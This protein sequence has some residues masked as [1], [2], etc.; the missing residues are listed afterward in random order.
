[1][2]TPPPAAKETTVVI[3]LDFWH[4]AKFSQIIKLWL[5]FVYETDYKFLDTVNYDDFGVFFT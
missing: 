4:L 2:I 3:Q 5:H 1:M